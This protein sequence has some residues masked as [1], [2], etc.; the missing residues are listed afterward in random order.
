VLASD[1]CVR[2]FINAWGMQTNHIQGGDRY[3]KP[4]G[5]HSSKPGYFITST[6]IGQANYALDDGSVLT[7][8]VE[9]WMFVPGR[10]IHT[11]HKGWAI[12]RDFARP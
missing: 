2:T 4:N 7:R 5:H 10:V 3:T 1:I 6:G 9:S 12:P 11:G 8:T